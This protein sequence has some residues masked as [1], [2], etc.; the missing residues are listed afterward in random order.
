[1]IK[2]ILANKIATLYVPNDNDANG[3]LKQKLDDLR[4]EHKDKTDI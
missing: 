1:M 4:N 3:T 2:F